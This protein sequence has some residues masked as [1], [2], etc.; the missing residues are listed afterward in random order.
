M[1]LLATCAYTELRSSAAIKSKDDTE[2]LQRI[3]QDE[4][5]FDI[6]S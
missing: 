5:D 3:R 6:W 4:A 2:F 1:K